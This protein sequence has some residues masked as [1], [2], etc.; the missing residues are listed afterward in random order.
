MHP[1][2]TRAQRSGSILS[3]CAFERF[4]LLLIGLKDMQRPRDGA[5]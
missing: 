5:R 1:H 2:A 3:S 4:E